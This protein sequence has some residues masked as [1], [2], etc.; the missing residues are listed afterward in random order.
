MPDSAFRKRPSSSSAPVLDLNAPPPSIFGPSRLDD[1]ALLATGKLE[2]L[3]KVRRR[4]Y[5][6]DR[7]YARTHDIPFE[8]TALGSRVVA[9][10]SDRAAKTAQKAAQRKATAIAEAA[11]AATDI[12]HRLWTAT[13]GQAEPDWL[14]KARTAAALKHSSATTSTPQASMSSLT[15]RGPQESSTSGQARPL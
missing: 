7:R 9:E 3:R 13:G 8:L 1:E 4:Q 11:S 2:D 14:K 12:A 15:G 6:R 10:Q 5:R